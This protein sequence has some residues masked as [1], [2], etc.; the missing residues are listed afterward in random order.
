MCINNNLMYLSFM[1]V[2]PGYFEKFKSILKIGGGVSDEL[3]IQ[4]FFDS[5]IFLITTIQG[6]KELVDPFAVVSYAG[7]EVIHVVCIVIITLE[8]NHLQMIMSILYQTLK[9]P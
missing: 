2:D 4:N 1:I 9:Q 6:Q 7:H 8:Y 3:S 5:R